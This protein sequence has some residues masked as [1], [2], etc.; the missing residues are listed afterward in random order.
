MMEVLKWSQEELN[1][2]SKESG[3]LPI[4]LGSDDK[5]WAPLKAPGELNEA[6][7]EANVARVLIRP[8]SWYNSGFVTVLANRLSEGKSQDLTSTMSL[9]KADC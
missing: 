1:V 6:K 4:L 8:D 5:G 2:F 3:Y 9:A 7:V